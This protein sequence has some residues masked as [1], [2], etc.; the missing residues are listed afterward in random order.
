MDAT[1][2][3]GDGSPPPDP[4]DRT[5]SPP[6][7]SDVLSDGRIKASIHVSELDSLVD[8]TL[9]TMHFTVPDSASS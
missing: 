4:T 5:E 9:L 1:V 7:P 2:E 3:R 6:P 8:E